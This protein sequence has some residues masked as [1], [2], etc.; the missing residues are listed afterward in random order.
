M[1]RSKTL[2]ALLILV[3]GFALPA[4]PYMKARGKI[5]PNKVRKIFSINRAIPQNNV[6]QNDEPGLYT[7]SLGR[8]TSASSKLITRIFEN[9]MYFFA[10]A[11]V[12]GLYDY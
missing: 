10:V 11:A 7:C 6:Q 1:S 3:V 2:L 5:L 9:L 8:V 4:A 12:I